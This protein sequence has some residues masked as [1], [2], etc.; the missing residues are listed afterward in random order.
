VKNYKISLADAIKGIPLTVKTLDAR[1]ITMMVDELISPKTCKEFVGEGMPD[2]NGC[3]GNLYIKFDICFPSQFST[4]SR[5]SIINALKA[6][7]SEL[8]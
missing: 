5:V 1:N 6:N 4:G 3:K 2:G 7:E 8:S